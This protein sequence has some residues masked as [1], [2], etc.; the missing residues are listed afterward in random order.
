MFFLND[1][2]ESNFFRLLDLFNL[3]RT[4]DS[5]Y[6]ATLY[7][8]AV[9]DIFSL[10]GEIDTNAGSPLN[11]LTIWDEEEETLV[12]SSPALTGTTRRLV[13]FGLSCFNGYKI[14]LDDLL[15]YVNDDNFQVLLE[16]MRIRKGIVS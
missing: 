7:I 6:E 9:P 11:Q 1:E 12:I 13:G 10:L 2:H 15:G 16:T 4:K 5:Q 8:S 14:D 3:I